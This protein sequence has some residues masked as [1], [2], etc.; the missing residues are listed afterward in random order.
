MTL[1][2]SLGFL[3]PGGKICNPMCNLLRLTLS[4]F[5][6]LNLSFLTYKTDTANHLVGLLRILK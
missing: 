5:T 3:L 1:D 2:Y 4:K 6:S